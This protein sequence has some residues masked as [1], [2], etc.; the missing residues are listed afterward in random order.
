MN[1]VINNTIG[2]LGG[3][4]DP[5]HV[6]HLKIS[7]LSIKKLRSSKLYWII[8]KKNP[9][10]KKPFFTLDER[11]L[12][13]KNLTKRNSKIK[14]QYLEKELKSTRSIKIVNFFKKN[15]KNKKVYLIIGSDNLLNFHKWDSW[16][17]IL[18]MC[19]LVVFSR[20]GFDKKAQKSIIVRYLKNKN[21][22]FIKNKKI[23]ISSTKLRKILQK[24]NI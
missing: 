5:P 7:S 1:K 14:I 18:K 3:S 16:K 23:D 22:I 2:I 11:I 13:C 8:T 21:I 9:F 17:K 10:K 15:K 12:K 19:E 20:K 24:R 4:F 6:G